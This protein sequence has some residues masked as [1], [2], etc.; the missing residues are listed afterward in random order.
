MIRRNSRLSIPLILRNHLKHGEKMRIF[1]QVVNLFLIAVYLQYIPASIAAEPASSANTILNFNDFTPASYGGGQDGGGTVTIENAGA[2]LRLTGNRWQ[3]IAFNYTITADTVIEFDYSSDIEG[4][5]H[6]I[7][8]DNNLSL[9]ADRTLK[10]LGTQAWGI[11][12][13]DNYSTGSGTQHYVIPVGQYYTGAMNYLFFVNDH[14]VSNPD[15]ESLFSNIQV[16][17]DAGPTVVTQPITVGLGKDYTTPAELAA[18]N[19][20]QP[21]DIVEIDA[22]V[23]PADVAVWSTDN[24]TLRGVGG[25]VHLRADGANAQGKGI[26]VINGDNTVVENIEFSGATVPDKNGAG[27]RHQGG[28][29]TVRNCYFHGNEMGILTG[30]DENSELIVENSEFDDN[31]FGDGYSH[32]IYVGRIKKFTLKYSY[33]HHTYFGT[34]A[35]HNVKSRAQQNFI[36][37]NRIMDESD[38]RASRQVDLPNG[39]RS[40]LI[41]NLIQQGAHATNSDMLGYANEGASNTIQELYV[42][43]N[44]FVNDKHSGSF[45]HVNSTPQLWVKNNIFVGGGSVP[46]GNNVENNLVTNNAG[47]IDPAALDYHLSDLSVAID[48]GINPGIGADGF[49][50]TPLF[51]Y[52]HITQ[53]GVRPIDSQLDIGAFEYE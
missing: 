12:D 36:L 42:V 3:Q 11:L 16:Y 29:L 41:G 48:Q 20:L 38:G 50:L 15:A 18:A 24:I 45:I 9:S 4:E 44:T 25:M 19:I 31:G 26:W 43:N 46:T 17:E 33:S 51:E 5:I 6:G 49:N 7:G 47:L 23:Y 52:R 13:F 14:D 21:G 32:N 34:D 30:N 35:G 28:L 8:F 1:K 22:G 37:Y 10:L 27:I 2:S 53:G 39:G 40:Y